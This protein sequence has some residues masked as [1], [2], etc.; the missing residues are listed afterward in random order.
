MEEGIEGDEVRVR[1]IQ[2]ADVDV[3]WGLHREW[4]PVK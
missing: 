3:V 2:P 1:P 4:F